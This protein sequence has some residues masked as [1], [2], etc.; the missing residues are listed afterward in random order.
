M[1]PQ[2]VLPSTF[3]ATLQTIRRVLPDHL[4]AP[5]IGIVCGSGLAGLADSFRDKVIVPYSDLEGFGHST[6][7][8]HLSALAFGL[9]GPGTGVPVV[10]MLGRVSLG[11][12]S[13][14]SFING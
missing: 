11:A 7:A 12:S 8:G 13:Q 1:A 5:R 4:Q 14:V 6:V 9:L 10:A 2:V 3:A